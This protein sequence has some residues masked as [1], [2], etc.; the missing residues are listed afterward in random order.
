MDEEQ[1]RCPPAFPAVRLSVKVTI[2]VTVTVPDVVQSCLLMWRAVALWLSIQ[3]L[4][5]EIRT[6]D[7]PGSISSA[8][9][10]FIA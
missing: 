5:P 2:T 3:V 1:A 9:I 10:A 7:N 8:A 6:C 4:T